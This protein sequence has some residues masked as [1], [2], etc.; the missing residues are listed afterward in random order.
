MK[1]SNVF[2]PRFAIAEGTLIFFTGAVLYFA[3]EMIWRGY[4]HISMPLLG[5]L[6]FLSLYF[7]GSLFPNMP[8]LLY[9]ILGGAVISLLELGTGAFLNL[10]L[11]LDI[12]DYSSLPLNYKGQVC[13]LFSFFWCLLCMPANV[14]ARFMRTKIFGYPE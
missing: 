12:W 8:M 3:I 5:G 4:S 13:L 14:L 9:C 10:G 2:I 11:G 6:C 1:S 7:I